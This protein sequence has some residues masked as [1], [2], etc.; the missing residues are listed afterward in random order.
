V[1]GRTSCFPDERIG[2]ELLNGRINDISRHI[3]HLTTIYNTGTARAS[4]LI[5]LHS[6]NINI[7]NV[8]LDA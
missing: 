6:I 8:P 2:D 5:A 4:R 1:D 3:R 7:C